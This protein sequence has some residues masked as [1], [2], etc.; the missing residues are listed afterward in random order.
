MLTRPSNSPSILVVV[1]AGVFS[2]VAA[3]ITNPA[4]FEYVKVQ[5]KMMIDS[6]VFNRNEHS[7]VDG[8]YCVYPHKVSRNETAKPFQYKSPFEKESVHPFQAII[9]KNEGCVAP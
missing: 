5:A 8:D 7:D 4:G 3:A 1:T 9:P 6:M 2:I